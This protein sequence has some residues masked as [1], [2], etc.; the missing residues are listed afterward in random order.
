MYL[1]EADKICMQNSRLRY[2]LNLLQKPLGEGKGGWDFP[3]DF[4]R[5]KVQRHEMNWLKSW[6]IIYNGIVLE[7]ITEISDTLACLRQ[8][9]HAMCWEVLFVP[10]HRFFCLLKF[11]SFLKVQRVSKFNLLSEEICLL[12][13]IK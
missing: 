8:T 5:I 13:N 11:F 4:G 7:H 6:I 3:F 1:I 10:P 2:S 9:F 12:L